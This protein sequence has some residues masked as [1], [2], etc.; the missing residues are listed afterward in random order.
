[1][2]FSRLIA[3]NDRSQVHVV[4]GEVPRILKETL[5]LLKPLNGMRFNVLD[6]LSGRQS[7]LTSQYV[8]HESSS[9]F[10]ALGHGK[11]SLKRSANK[12]NFSL[13]VTF[14]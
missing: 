13:L 10:N 4:T 8:S 3:E 6:T 5:M 11:S 9:A 2:V 7:L 12:L 1:M 14:L